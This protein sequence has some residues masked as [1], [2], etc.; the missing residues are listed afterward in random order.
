M[1]GSQTVPVPARRVNILQSETPKCGYGRDAR[2][3]Q[4]S[5]DAGGRCGVP[6]HFAVVQ[7]EQ[8]WKTN[9]AQFRKYARKCVR[10]CCC[11]CSAYFSAAAYPME[12]HPFA[13]IASRKCSM[14]MQPIKSLSAAPANRFYCHILTVFKLHHWKLDEQPKQREIA[15]RERVTALRRTHTKRASCIAS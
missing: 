13:E 9:C 11:C 4:A 8:K 2:A 1:N 6:P 14:E 15:E 10:L 12:H 5:H 3:K 7:C